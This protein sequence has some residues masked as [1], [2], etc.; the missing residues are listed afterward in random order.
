MLCGLGRWLGVCVRGSGL[1]GVAPGLQSGGGGGGCERGRVERE[2]SYSS[3]MDS[4]REESWICGWVWVI[5][6]REIGWFVDFGAYVDN[7]V[8]GVTA[9]AVQVGLLCGQR[10]VIYMKQR[11]ALRPQCLRQT[12]NTPRHFCVTT[13][14]YMNV[15]SGSYL[16][17]SIDERLSE[18][19]YE[20]N[21]YQIEPSG[22]VSESSS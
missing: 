4:G 7:K 20:R 1:C 13:L 8:P 19:L 10:H 3:V 21:G 17:C 14:L 16:Q 2:W 15:W 11:L 18:K 12:T 9:G 6:E 22:C 5:G